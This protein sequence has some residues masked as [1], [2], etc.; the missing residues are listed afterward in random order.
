MHHQKMHS[1]L[2]DARQE[3]ITEKND[4]ILTRMIL[5]CTFIHVNFNLPEER[6]NE[7]L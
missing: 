4:D 7:Y 6:F 3:W 2:K 1:E 5:V